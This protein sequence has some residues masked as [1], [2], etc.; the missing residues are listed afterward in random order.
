MAK[1]KVKIKKIDYKESIISFL[2]GTL[3][4]F[5]FVGMC[6]AIYEAVNWQR[7]FNKNYE[8]TIERINRPVIE[9]PPIVGTTTMP[10]EDQVWLSQFIRKLKTQKIATQQLDMGEMGDVSLK[11]DKNWLIKINLHSQVDD[12]WNT[13][14][15]IYVTGDLQKALKEGLEYIDLRFGNKVFYKV[16]AKESTPVTNLPV[17]STTTSTTTDINIPIPPVDIV[18]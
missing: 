1:Q 15:S 17:V 9:L 5:I 2:K 7:V 6:L 18:H 13:F 4:L 12:I 11:T 8:A 3:Y 16:R 14:A 10:Y